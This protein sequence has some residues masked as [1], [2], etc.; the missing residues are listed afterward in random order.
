MAETQDYFLI[1]TSST[2]RRDGWSIYSRRA[3]SVYSSYMFS[4]AAFFFVLWDLRKISRFWLLL[5]TFIGWSYVFTLRKPNLAPFSLTA[6]DDG[7]ACWIA[8]VTSAEPSSFE[9]RVR[10]G[11]GEWRWS[12]PLREAIVFGS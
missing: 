1:F 7:R 2:A 9:I 12:L 6:D 11:K 5:V 4:I 8:R 3:R 10:P